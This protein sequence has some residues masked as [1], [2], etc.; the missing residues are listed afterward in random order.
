MAFL[1]LSRKFMFQA[2]WKNKAQLFKKRLPRDPSPE[3]TCVLGSA[4]PQ[5]AGHLRPQ[6]WG[7]AGRC[8]WDPA[9]SRPVLSPSG[10][11]RPQIAARCPV[12]AAEQGRE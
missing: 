12:E 7:P 8:V 5:A 10:D 6:P 11:R 1:N 2:L 9:L 4:C 3:P